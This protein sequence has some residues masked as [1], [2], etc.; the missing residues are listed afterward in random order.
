MTSKRSAFL[1]IA[2][3]VTVALVL[4][5]TACGASS[6]SSST[7]RS[8]VAEVASSTTAATPLR[9]NVNLSISNYAYH[10]ATITVATGARATFTN[11]DQ[12][13]HTATSTKTAFDT[14]TFKPGHSATIL[15][16]QSGRYTYYCQF[17]PFMHG[18]IIV[19]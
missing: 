4:A 12:T 8:T 6:S 10:P 16:K 13:S 19:T 2:P 18:A 11:H 14:G 15:L 1:A 9:G 5:L 7:S 3:V 17:H